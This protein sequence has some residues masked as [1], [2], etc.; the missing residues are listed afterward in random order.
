MTDNKEAADKY[1]KIMYVILTINVAILVFM[2]GFM[3]TNSSAHNNLTLM[4]NDQIHW[5]KTVHQYE[6]KANTELTR[7]NAVRLDIQ[8]DYGYYHVKK[9]DSIISVYQKKI[10]AQ[11]EVIRLLQ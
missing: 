4:L 9:F 11:N 1:L 5:T 6:I 8:S 7:S 3:V 10:I 2:L